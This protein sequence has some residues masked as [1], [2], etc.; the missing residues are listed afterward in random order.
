MISDIMYHM[1]ISD[2]CKPMYVDFNDSQNINEITITQTNKYGEGVFS[3]K[4]NIFIE[5]NGF[6][7]WRCAA[8]SDFMNRLYKNNRKY[9]FTKEIN[10]F[11]RIHKNSLTQ[12]SNTSG[13]SELRAK[14]YGISSNRKNFNP[15]PQLI[16]NHFYEIPL[17]RFQIELPKDDTHHKTNRLKLLN[18]LI[19]GSSKESKTVDYSSLSGILNKESYNPQVSNKIRV[20]TPNKEKEFFNLKDDSNSRTT[21]QLSNIKPNRRKNSPNIFGSKKK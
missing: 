12:S 16:T 2:F 6:E 17:N 4:K 15:L 1:E 14:Y 10:F 7:G 18:E 20:N 21:Q 8:D 19:N 11:R 9:S 3:I 5:M 13:G